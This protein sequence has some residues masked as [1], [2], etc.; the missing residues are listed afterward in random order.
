MIVCVCNNLSDRRL[1]SA[2][3]AT[4]CP[5]PGAL[6]RAMGCRPRCGRC[7]PEM[8]ALAQ[9]GHAAQ[10]AQPREAVPASAAEE[11]A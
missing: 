2:A 9:A 6:F 4:D 10:P 11:A 1:R 8:R 3:A 7:L 5:T